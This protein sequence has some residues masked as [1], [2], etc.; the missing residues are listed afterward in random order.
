MLVKSGPSKHFVDPKS[1]RGVESRMLNCTEINPP[2]EIKAADH[3]TLFGTAQGI[4]L[5]LVRD[6]QYVCRTVNY[7]YFLFQVW[8]EI[9]FLQLWQLK[10]VSKLFS[11]R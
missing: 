4:I 3:N 2:M 1:I 10:K 7:Q 8:G 9:Y 5:I 11:L 6:T